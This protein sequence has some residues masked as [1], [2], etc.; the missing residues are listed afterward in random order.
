MAVVLAAGV[1]SC[2]K[3]D[4]FVNGNGD[5][6]TGKVLKSSLSVDLQ[7]EEGLPA[8]FNV[9]TRAQAPTADDFTVDFIKDGE[10]DPYVSYVY[11]EM[12]EVVTLPVGAFKAVARYGQ[13]EAAAW[14]APYFKGE[15]SFVVV[16]DK[17]TENVEPIVAK[18][19]NVRV[20]IKF[21][22]SLKAA[23]SDDSKVVVKVGESATTLDFTAADEERSAYF[24]YVEGSNTLTATFTGAV[25]GYP[26]VESKVYDDVKPGSHYAV[27]FKLHDVADDEEGTITPGLTVDATVEVENLTVTFDPEEDEVIED[28][29][30]P[31]EGGGDNPG[32]GPEDPTAPAPKAEPIDSSN[33][34]YA[35]FKRVDLDKE[36]EVTSDLSCAWKVISEAEGGFKSFTVD[37]ISDTLTPEELEGVGLQQHLDLVNPGEFKEPL[38]GLGFPVEIGGLSEAEFDITGFLSLMSVLGEANHEFKMTVTDANGTSVIS[39]RLHTN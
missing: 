34:D 4:P 13:N 9:A 11:G 39:L 27:T 19:S 36:N 31:V 16:A 24:A 12:P 5:E 28:D 2:S 7:N 35:G 8:I 14:E 37:I 30:R 20:S 10:S 23:M 3:E 25:E 21:A 33:P 32:P 29:L 1:A 22:P 17:I 18:L 6:Q 15:T 26:V 38:A